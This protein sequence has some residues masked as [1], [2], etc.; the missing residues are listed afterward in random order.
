MN[1]NEKVTY[2]VEISDYDLETAK[3]MFRTKRYLYVGF[4]C[5]QVIEK[6]F[7]A[8]FSSVKEETPPYIH[9]LRRLAEISGLIEFLSKEQLLFIKELAPMNIEARYPVYKEDLLK[10]LTLEKCNQL[11]TKT[12]ELCTWL[13]QRL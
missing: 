9:N 4:M 10:V 11:I 13:K 6:V 7:K 2:W 8:Y 5:H 3:A 1:T 12:E